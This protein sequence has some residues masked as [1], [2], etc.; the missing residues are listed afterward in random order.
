MIKITREELSRLKPMNN[1]V[2]IKNIEDRSKFKLTDDIEIKLETD[3]TEFAFR[4]INII[5]KVIAVPDKIQF[6]EGKSEWETTMELSIGD[7][8]VVNQFPLQCAV[9]NKEFYVCEGEVYY[10]IR[11]CDI[12]CKQS[13][14]GF[15]K[16]SFT[17]D[18]KE[19]S[20][21]PVMELIPLNGYILAEPI[22]KQE[23]FGVYQVEKETNQAIVKFVGTPNTKHLKRFKPESQSF[24]EPIEQEVEAGDV[25]TFKKFT[26]AVLDKGL[27][28]VFGNMVVIARKDIAIYQRGDTIYG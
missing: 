5:N 12:Y 6:G 24:Y 25:V 20:A 14:V 8:V 2:L 19:L 7:T 10:Y 3:F 11:Y 15:K 26:N 23:G 16:L 4:H 13:V 22:T 21:E 28:K 18:F 9:T 1:L 27:K 17:D